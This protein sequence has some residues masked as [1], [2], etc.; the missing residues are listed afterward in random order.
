MKTFKSLRFLAMLG[1][2][3]GL[4][5]LGS[6]D[7]TIELPD[8][9]FVPTSK[10]ME[11][12]RNQPALDSLEKYLDL[13]P[14]LVNELS[15]TGDFT[16]FAPNN[17]AFISLLATPGFPSD[18]RS[19]NPDIIKSVLAYH[20]AAVHYDQA[21]LTSG[22]SI[23]TVQGESIV[24]NADGT[25]LTGS[26]N[27]AIEI[28]IADSLATNGV[29]HIVGSVM[30]PPSIGEKI[31]PLLGTNLGTFMLGADF[32]TLAAGILKADTFATVNSLPTLSSVLIG[33][34]KHAVFAPTN[35][36]FAAGSLTANSFTGQQWYG[37]ISNHI[38]MQEIL[39]SDLTTG[40]TFNTRYTLDGVTFGKLTIF[41]NTQIVPAKH[42]VGIYID[43]NGDVDVTLAD[44]GASLNNLD[45]ELA[46][47]NAVSN[48]NGAIHAIAGVLAP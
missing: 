36:T 46:L 28:V 4:I 38:V 18:I 17:A 3:G 22:T 8:P 41:N 2:A 30:I 47:F 10:I 24:V 29:M 25:L 37:I 45:A 6:C 34:T 31:T 5:V 23:S 39:E 42:G 26:S 35:A 44:G 40:K 12:V 16:F 32:T 19:I 14:N 33:T 43:S 7:K 21:D 1:I 11:I 20:I 9:V 48:A 15:G 13:F 27:K